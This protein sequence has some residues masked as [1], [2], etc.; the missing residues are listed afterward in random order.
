MVAEVREKMAAEAAAKGG[1]GGGPGGGSGGGSG[2]GPGRGGGGA[3]GRPGAK[4]T[5]EKKPSGKP[6][7]ARDDRG[8]LWVKDGDLVRPI[9]VK[10]GATDGLNTEVVGD[11]VEGDKMEDGM[12]IVLSE[13][14][15]DRGGGDTTNPFA[16]KLF[17]GRPKQ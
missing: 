5:G 4:P 8:R 11:K 13:I 1:R 14:R 3:E 16:P 7:K 17:Q 2:G 10:I 15:A 6:E 12:E 9:E